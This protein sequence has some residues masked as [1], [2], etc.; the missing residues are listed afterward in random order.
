MKH[1]IASITTIQCLNVMENKQKFEDARKKLDVKMV[2]KENP[3][4]TYTHN[5]LILLTVLPVRYVSDQVIVD[6]LHS[7]HFLSCNVMLIHFVECN[8]NEK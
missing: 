2:I 1:D 3:K 5:T 4:Y 7:Y 8:S 6:Y